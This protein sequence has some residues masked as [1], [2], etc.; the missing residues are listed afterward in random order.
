VAAAAKGD[1]GLVAFGIAI[2]VPIIVWGSKLVL[3]LMDRFPWVITAGAGL[4][5]WIGGGMLVHDVVL[6]PRLAG[7]PS[8]GSYVAAAVGAAF[9]VIVGIS[10]RRA[11]ATT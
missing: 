3:K 4:L 9:V 10:T 6:Q 1:I 8:W 2:S 5:G 7:M 11:S